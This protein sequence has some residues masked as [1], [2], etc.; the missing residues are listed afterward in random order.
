MLK[1][2]QKIDFEEILKITSLHRFSFNFDQ[3]GLGYYKFKDKTSNVGKGAQ[4]TIDNGFIWDAESIAK[5]SRPYDWNQPWGA[6]QNIM[7]RAS[8]PQ[9][10]TLATG[11]SKMKLK[12][13]YCYNIEMIPLSQKMHLKR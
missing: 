11:R 5:Y 7:A 13:K 8:K 10:S 1:I 4:Y 2:I 9:T 6:P 3:S 12:R